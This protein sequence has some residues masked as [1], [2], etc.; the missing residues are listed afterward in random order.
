MDRPSHLLIKG[1]D[2]HFSFEL[3]PFMGEIPAPS[4]KRLFVLG[5]VAAPPFV[6]I[7]VFF[8]IL[9]RAFFGAMFALGFLFVTAQQW[10]H[11]NEIQR[12]QAAR[13]IVE[14]SPVTIDV[15][16]KVD[17]RLSESLATPFSEIDAIDLRPKADG[18][19]TLRIL[20]PEGKLVMGI[21]IRVGDADVGEWLVETLTE[22]LIH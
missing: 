11:R 16:W 22:R 13:V 1:N 19:Q 14:L 20:G 12:H 6:F 3:S 17:N 7:V 4:F 18:S 21:P 2:D 8:P 5:L 10:L 9:S 15:R